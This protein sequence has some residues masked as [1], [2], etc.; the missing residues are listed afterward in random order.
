MGDLEQW[1][2]QDQLEKEDQ[3]VE[4]GLQVC[5]VTLDQQVPLDQ[6]ASVEIQV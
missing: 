2:F 6:K 3:R 1:V 4:R 5:E